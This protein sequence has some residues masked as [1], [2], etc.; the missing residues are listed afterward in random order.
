MKIEQKHIMTIIIA[1]VSTTLSYVI[2]YYLNLGPI[3]N[4]QPAGAVFAGSAVGIIAALFFKDYAVTGYV[5]AFVGMSSL[6]VIPSVEYTLLFGFICGIVCIL[7][8]PQFAGFGGKAG[9]TAWLSVIITLYMLVVTSSLGLLNTQLEDYFK[10]LTPIDPTFL[11]AAILAG[12]SGILATILLREQV[13]Q[14]TIKARALKVNEAVLGS[15]IVGLVGS[16]IVP[17]IPPS[18]ITTRLPVI[19]V[20]GTYAGMASRKILP[21]TMDFLLTGIL[22]GVINVTTATVFIGFGGGLGLRAM[23]SIIVLMVAWRLYKK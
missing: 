11:V 22:V 23:L 2:N 14:K 9:T 7:Y 1:M 10:N 18:I 15:A 20:S 8:A 21:T 12:V 5:G 16:I 6:K 19:L 13:L 17:W 4:Y 3:N